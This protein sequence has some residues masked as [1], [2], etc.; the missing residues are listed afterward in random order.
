MR[1][2]VPA[3]PLLRHAPPLPFSA[4]APCPPPLLY[5]LLPAA[6]RSNCRAAPTPRSSSPPAATTRRAPLR[7]R[8]A[9][10]PPPT[11]RR[12]LVLRPPLDDAVEQAGWPAA[13][14]GEAGLRQPPRSEA[15]DGFLAPL[16]ALS[17]VEACR[18]CGGGGGG[19]ARHATMTAAVPKSSPTSRRSTVEDGH[20][21][22]GLQGHGVCG[23]G[24]ARRHAR[25]R[26]TRLRVG[27]GAAVRG[28]HRC[29][30]VGARGMGQ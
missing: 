17:V 4:A 3:A 11:A 8:P 18:W 15:T 22:V 16:A 10:L 5:S 2:A 27:D 20:S 21:G 26:G 6:P 28:A 30:S 13:R 24:G 19:E 7:L 29:R 9:V 12:A 23:L 14:R 25:P 1:S